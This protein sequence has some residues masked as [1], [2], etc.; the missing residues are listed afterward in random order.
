M[1]HRRFAPILILGS[2]WLLAAPAASASAIYK[3]TDDKGAIYYA[4]SFDPQRCAGGGA[5]LNEQGIAIREI[6]RI[7]TPAERAED[8]AAAA[9]AAE[10]QRVQDAQLK[11]DQV[12]LMSYASEDDLRRTNRQALEIINS[13]V[14]TSR[15]QMQ[16]HERDLAESLARA[17]DIE[18]ADGS[19]PAAVTV[20]IDQLRTLIEDQ[21]AA[22]TLKLAEKA[23]ANL[24]F[25]LRLIRYR[26]LRRQQTERLK[27]DEI[28]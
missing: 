4:Q 25:T 2:A 19:V 24:N 22:I 18:R 17:A 27:D 16:R 5:Q 23:Q 20:Q 1:P 14:E 9:V 13:S 21:R 3:C 11:A 10:A 15:L 12:L 7:K 26:E 8:K 28:G 6:E